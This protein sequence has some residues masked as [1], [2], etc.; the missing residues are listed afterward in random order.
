MLG[1][2]ADD[3]A[4]IL[5]A[6]SLS[7]TFIEPAQRYIE[8]HG[9]CLRAGAAA[10]VAFAAGRAVGVELRDERLFAAAVISAVPWHALPD[11][12]GSA[13]PEALHPVV[14]RALAMRSSPIVTVN[15]WFDRRVLDTPFLGL[16]GR[17][18]QWSF[19]R[20][21]VT[22]G[23]ATYVSLVCSG[24]D[25]VVELPNEALVARAHAELRQAVPAVAGAR[26]LRGTAV[27][28]RRATFSL[29]ADEPA[30]PATTTG[31]PGLFLAG[32]W[33]DTGLPGTIES[34]VISGHRAAAAVLRHL[35]RRAAWQRDS[36]TVGHA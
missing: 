34:A 17:S 23:E 20:G 16:P 12:C 25:D 4:L 24:A 19:D 28:E 10:R 3:A 29:A 7:R 13:S 33:I 31:V 21:Q 5:P 18:F 35:G 30:R 11:L 1:P 27:R 14:Q 2:G 32:D 8:Q 9:G 15:L 26:L 22:P 36:V 6:T